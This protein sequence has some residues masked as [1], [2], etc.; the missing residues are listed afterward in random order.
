MPTSSK[1]LVFALAIE[2]N[3]PP[4]ASECLPFRED[5]GRYELL[6]PPL[7]VKNLSVGDLI[8]ATIDEASQCVFEWHHVSKSGHTT[9][10]LG[11]M[12]SSDTIARVLAELRELGCHTVRFEQGGVYAIDV[13]PSLEMSAVDAVLARLDPTAVAVAFPSMRHEE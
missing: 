2:G 7:F 9:V 13:D 8:E 5:Q 12:R 6:A 3:W 10:W 11:R 1:S 4:V